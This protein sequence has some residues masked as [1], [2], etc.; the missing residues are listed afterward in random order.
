MKFIKLG[1]SGRHVHLTQKTLDIL[2]GCQN[3]QLTFFKNLQQKGQFAAE[4]KIDVM[5]SLGKILKNV[6]ILGPSRNID[7]VEIS[8][9]DNVRYQFNACVRSSGDIVGSAPATLIGPKGQV[10]ISEG[11]IIADRHIHLSPEDAKNFNVQDGQIV[12]IKIKGIKSGILG[13]V[14]CRVNPTFILE[15]HLDTD[16]ACS[17][18]LKSGDVVELINERLV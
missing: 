5:S 18:L 16:D 7:Q 17:F 1:V 6:R 3:Y 9:S 8:Q 12:N 4:E 15:C 14:L 2:F 10:E 13:N 11:V